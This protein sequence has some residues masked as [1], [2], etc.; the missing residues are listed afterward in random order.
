[1]EI[2]APGHAVRSA[3]DFGI[4]LLIVTLG[5]L[6][7]LSLEGLR[8]WRHERGLVR[9]ANANIVNELRDNKKELDGLLAAM[10][11]SRQKQ[12]TIL[13]FIHDVGE[14][15]KSDIHQLE[16]NFHLAQLRNTSWST[17]QTVG[18]LGYM[19]YADVKKFAGV[20]ELQEVY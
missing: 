18:A 19:E 4:H 8:E 1:M 2:H 7:A 11:A 14:H 13:T 15:G 17:A 10:P 16:L 6:I 9:E 5:I 3:K 12:V 20:Y